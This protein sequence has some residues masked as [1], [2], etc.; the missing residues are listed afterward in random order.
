MLDSSMVLKKE[1]KKKIK[2]EER[3]VPKSP[4]KGIQSAGDS[5]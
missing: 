2:P 1:I 5:N 4:L 3:N